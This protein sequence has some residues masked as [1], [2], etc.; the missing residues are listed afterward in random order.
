MLTS[1]VGATSAVLHLMFDADPLISVGQ[2]I[3]VPASVQPV[4]ETVDEP[5]VGD[6]VAA[7]TLVPKSVPPTGRLNPE[8]NVP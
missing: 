5:P 3:M 4:E 7:V 8:S 1:C 2:V 6:S